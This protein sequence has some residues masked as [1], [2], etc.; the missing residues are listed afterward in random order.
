M[1]PHDSNTT[2]REMVRVIVAMVPGL[3]AM[4]WI[5]GPGVWI[6]ALIM[7][8][9]AI[10]A[11]AAILKL[12][13]R[14]P[15]PSLRDYSAVLTALLLAASLPPLLPWWLV[16][17]G[18]AIAIILAKQL[19][20]GLGQNPFN[21]AMVGYAILLISFPLEMTS[22]LPVPT[23]DPPSWGTAWEAILEIAPLPPDAI[24]NATP[25]GGVK[26]GL[27][28]GLTLQQAL[29]PLAPGVLAGAG[30]EWINLAFLLGGIALLLSGTITWQIPVGVVAG[31][32]L[33]A[34]LFHALDPT[35]YA[36]PIYHLF[37]GGIM[38]GAFFI[39]TDPVTASTTP[40]GRLWFGIGVGVLDYIIRTWGGYPDAIAFSVLLMNAFTPLIDHFTPT[41]IYGSRQR[42]EGQ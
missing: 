29:Q 2:S 4:G 42:G 39:A 18:T 11:E 38:L 36:G 23:I 15:L 20:G 12:R 41:T 7:V 14:N 16:M 5:F 1:V 19:Y 26:S 30:W 13:H 9:T 32:A 25:L 8:P 10:V 33:P 35:L 37:S 6:H 27:S 17:L 21:P 31:L 3:G 34:L 28:Q 24:T 22:W 40:H